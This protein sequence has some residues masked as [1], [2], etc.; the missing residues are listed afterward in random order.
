M[1][2]NKKLY[3]KSNALSFNKNYYQSIN[4]KKIIEWFLFNGRS[5]DNKTFLKKI[6]VLD[7]GQ[8][9]IFQS[10][11]LKLQNCKTFNYQKSKLSLNSSIEIIFENLRKAINLRIGH[12]KKRS[13]SLCLEV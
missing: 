6:F 5:F 9:C 1:F 11:K 2:S 10:N 13:H 4:F 12:L 8:I 7:P 3:L